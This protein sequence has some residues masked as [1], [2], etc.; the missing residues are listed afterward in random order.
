MIDY[1]REMMQDGRLNQIWNGR[2]MI[3]PTWLG[4]ASVPSWGLQCKAAGAQYWDAYD[5][6][7]HESQGLPERDREVVRKSAKATLWTLA[8]WKTSKYTLWNRS[9][10]RQETPSR[11]SLHCHWE[12]KRFLQEYFDVLE[13]TLEAILMP[14]T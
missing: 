13:S 1:K 3:T 14:Q 5:H 8:E 4:Y 7:F 12:L 9:Q 2:V 10:T 11:I 6:S